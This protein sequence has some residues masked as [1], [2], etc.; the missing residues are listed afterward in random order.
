MPHL[1]DAPVE[2]EEAAEVVLEGQVRVI[3]QLEMAA[4]APEAAAYGAPSPG[5]PERQR[6]GVA[7]ILRYEADLLYRAAALTRRDMSR[8]RDLV[9]D[10]FER[11][12]RNVH[13]LVPGSNVRAWL[14]TIL[15]N[16]YQDLCRS[17]RTRAIVPLAD[18]YAERA[19]A[20]AGAA[21]ALGRGDARRSEGGADGPEPRSPGHL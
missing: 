20:G 6:F 3:T 10:T 1:V 14:Y 15:A 2:L 9:Q 8:A 11:A 18:D 5:A 12:I 16:R 4:S 21:A 17:D 7:D 13:R 19:R